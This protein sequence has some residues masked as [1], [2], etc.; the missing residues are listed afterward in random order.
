MLGLEDGG[1]SP[2]RSPVVS[3]FFDSAGLAALLTVPATIAVAG[4]GVYTAREPLRRL[5]RLIEVRSKL[6]KNSQAAR[7]ALSAEI[8]ALAARE[9]RRAAEAVP[10]SYILLI[11]GIMM[12]FLVVTFVGMSLLTPGTTLWDPVN[13]VAGPLAGMGLFGTLAYA[14]VGLAAIWWRAR[15]RRKRRR[16]EQSSAPTGAAITVQD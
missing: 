9:G 1:S 10:A 13:R 3:D 12:A 16:E 11:L 5:E 2:I 8:D 4:A 15:D 14:I 7:R 6:P